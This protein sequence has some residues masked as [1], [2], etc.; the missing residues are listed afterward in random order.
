MR[1]EPFRI[2][3]RNEALLIDYYELTMTQAYW[4]EQLTDTAVF[5]L[6]VRRLPADR[7]FLLACGLDEVLR[8]LED[9][10]F[11]GESLDALR[12]IGGL[13]DDFIDWLADVRFTGDV[14]AMPEGTPVFANEPILEIRAPLTEAQLVETFVMNQMHVATLF[15]SKAVRVVR[16]ARGHAVVDFG[17]RRMHGSDAGLKS[18]RA[19]HIAG[20]SSTSNVL[21]GHL[22]GIPVTGTMAHSYIQAHTT[23][24]DAFRAFAGQHPDTVLL[25]DTY[26]TLDGVRNVVRLAKEMGEAFSVRAI[27]LDSGDLAALSI[28]ARRILDDAGLEDVG[29]FVSGSLDEWAIEK[30][31]DDGAPIEGFG[32]GTA[33]AVS[34]DAPAVDLAYK[35]V[36]YAGRGRLKLSPGKPILPGPKQVFREE[37]DTVAVKDTIARADEDLPGRPLLVPVMH[38]GRRLDAG[39]ATLADTRARAAAEINALPSA[40]HTLTPA[41]PAYPVSM[42]AALRALQAD[43]ARELHEAMESANAG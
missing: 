33:M 41:D 28:G 5:S 30:L 10:R 43:L 21:A 35:L 40:L 42:S 31:L 16:A 36:E 22:Y 38:A 6:F 23:E 13:D 37:I 27:R 32:V 17:L 15:A 20:V 14:M 18:A 24:L 4:R 11:E 26:D 12:K 9:L 2:S 25:V 19:F 1:T 29:I 34:A 3:T 39:R 8:Y 7:N